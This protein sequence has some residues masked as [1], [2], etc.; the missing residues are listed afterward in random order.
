MKIS[1]KVFWIIN[2]VLFLF[3]FFAMIVGIDPNPSLYIAIGLGIIN[4]IT[5]LLLMVY[6]K[7]EN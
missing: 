6:K 5:F 2:M 3:C 4:F 1:V 7:I